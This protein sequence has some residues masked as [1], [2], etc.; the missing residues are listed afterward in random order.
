MIEV[1]LETILILLFR[2][3]GAFIRWIFLHRS[4]TLKSLVEDEPYINATISFLMIACSVLL[5]GKLFL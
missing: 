2:Y 3:P 1:I 4:R 5:I